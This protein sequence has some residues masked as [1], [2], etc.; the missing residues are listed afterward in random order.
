M[1]EQEERKSYR[2]R[3]ISDRSYI[4]FLPATCGG[5]R[6]RRPP[7]RHD[8]TRRE[9]A[10][11]ATANSSSSSSSFVRRPIIYSVLDDVGMGGF[12]RANAAA[13]ESEE[14]KNRSMLCLNMTLTKLF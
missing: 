12:S 2:G 8:P 13:K 4:F 7:I 11:G 6:S 9:A 10:T 5:P 14:D 3:G 1:S